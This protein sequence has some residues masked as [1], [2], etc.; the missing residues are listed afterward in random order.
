ML[1]LQLNAAYKTSIH[2][3]NCPLGTFNLLGQWAIIDEL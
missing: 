2:L 3:S 1:D